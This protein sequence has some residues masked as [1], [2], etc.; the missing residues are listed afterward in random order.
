MKMSETSDGL[1]AENLHL[2]IKF[3]DIIKNFYHIREPDLKKQHKNLTTVQ[4]QILHFLHDHEGCNQQALVQRRECQRSTVSTMLTQLE[5]LGLVV[6]ERNQQD[7][8]MIQLF[9]TPAGRPVAA[10]INDSFIQ[11]CED[12]MSDFSMAEEVQ[13]LDMIER[14]TRRYYDYVK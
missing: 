6:R 2:I 1:Q 10:A 13:F 14:F 3:A 9:L 8:R 12:C 5:S 4:M 7:R 11:Y